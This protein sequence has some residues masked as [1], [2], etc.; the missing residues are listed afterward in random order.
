MY[1]G[2]AQSKQNA[3]WSGKKM[4]DGRARVKQKMQAGRAKQSAVVEQGKKKCKM[5]EQKNARWTSKG[6][7]RSRTPSWVGSWVGRFGEAGRQTG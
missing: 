7:W 1:D 5:D 4:Y 2:R 3:R 6:I